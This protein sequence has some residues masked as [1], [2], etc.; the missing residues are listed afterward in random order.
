MGTGLM[1]C[2]QGKENAVLVFTKEN[3]HRLLK[4][5]GLVC[6]SLLFSGMPLTVFANISISE[7]LCSIIYLQGLM[8]SC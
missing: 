4:C 8:F 7:T 2:G 6:L 1:L 3:L 5:C